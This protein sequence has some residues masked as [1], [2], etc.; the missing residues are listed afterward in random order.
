MGVGEPGWSLIVEV[1]EGA[2]GKVA[3]VD[4]WRVEPGVAETDE[5]AGGVGGGM[6][7]AEEVA[8]LVE[9]GLGAGSLGLRVDL[10]AVHEVGDCEW[11]GA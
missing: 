4:V 10:P 6:G 8:D 7:L 2:L 3:R 11:H 9:L 1:G 5:R